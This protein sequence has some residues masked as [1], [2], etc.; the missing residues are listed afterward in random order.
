MN[1]ENIRKKIEAELSKREKKVV[2]KNA[3]DA[4]FSA[5]PR[6]IEA[7]RKV[8]SG[9]KEAL[10]EEKQKI[11]MEAI[12]QLLIRIDDAIS[13]NNGK[14]DG[15]DWKVIGGDIEAYGE[16]ATE[17]TGMNI[18]PDSGPVELKPGTH[19]KASGKNVDKITGLKIGGNSSD[20]RVN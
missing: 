18:S 5:F 8:L 13:N 7:L 11:T 1:E 6:Q 3:I 15:I 19:I 10:E 12:L 2:N 20:E 14:A 9:R 16:N 4:L 17:V